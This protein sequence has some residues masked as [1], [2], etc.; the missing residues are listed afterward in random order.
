[1][2]FPF[3]Y[4]LEDGVGV[5]RQ[6]DQWLR[7]HGHGDRQAEL[8]WAYHAVADL[9]PQTS[10]NLWSGH[11]F[12][13]VESW[14]DLQISF[15]LASL[16]LY[17]QAMGALR[18]T[19]ELG[20]L[21]IY[22]NID[23]DGHTDIQRWVRSVDDTPRIQDVVDRLRAH[24]NF[25][26]FAGGY[27]FA[28]RLL[29]LRILHAY[30]HTKGLRYSNH[31]GLMSSNTQTFEEAAL[32]EWLSRSEEVTQALL[33]LH[34]VK[35]PLGTVRLD[36]SAKFGID[37]PA[38]GGVDPHIV[39]RFESVL[40]P[41][42]WSALLPVAAG[43]P[44]VSGVIEHVAGLP[45]ITSDEIEAQIRSIDKLFIRGMGFDAWLTQEA[46]LR[47]SNHGETNAPAWEERIIHLRMW[48]EKNGLL[49]EGMIRPASQPLE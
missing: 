49:H 36:W 4:K 44:H 35:Y 12:P 24:Q 26:V 17:K 43:D 45:D 18:S 28:P 15:E 10:Q 5:A 7:D 13:W 32:V 23:D 1:M 6:T 14:E 11:F 27:D 21:S 25:K 48:A 39:D 42:V 29:D 9:I 8:M 37:T 19:L 34:L 40:G 22:W 41:A 16:G 20:L 47:E 33:M 30:V 31:M 46:S 3:T 2:T 38:F